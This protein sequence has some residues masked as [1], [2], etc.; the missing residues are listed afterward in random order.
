[1]TDRSTSIRRLVD[2]HHTAVRLDAVTE[3]KVT[4]AFAHESRRRPR[5]P[6]A[7]RTHDQDALRR[8]R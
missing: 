6:R 4:R 3:Q 5:P 8:P 2:D 1:M 7:G